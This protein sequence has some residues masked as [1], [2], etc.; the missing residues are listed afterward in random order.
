MMTIKNI[1]CPV[2]LS[3]I[4]RRALDYAMVLAAAYQARLRVLEVIDM[5]LPPTP[6]GAWL[7]Q[8]LSVEMTQAYLDELKGFVPPPGSRG[9]VPEI[10]VVEGPIVKEVLSEARHVPADLIVMGTHGRG[11]FERLVLGSVTEKVLRKAGCPI[12]TVPP[13]LPELSGGLAPFPSIVCAFDFSRASSHAL[14]YAWSLAR[15]T[16]GRL[17]VIHVVEWPFG[18]AHVGEVPLEIDA[19]RGGLEVDARRQLHEALPKGALATGPIEEV[20]TCGKPSHEILR[21]AR[22]RSAALIVMGVYGR[23][24][25][26]LAL[27]GS[28]THRVI[29]EAH[30]PVLTVRSAE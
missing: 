17:A 18:D 28:T 21:L 29:R 15:D 22:E 1:L 12:L 30:C 27:F 25:V 19:L 13:G 20:V 26:D 14:M 6:P 3:P 16:T 11:G 23:G 8:S 24:A 2:D 9:V 7:P 5:S 4:S 10:H